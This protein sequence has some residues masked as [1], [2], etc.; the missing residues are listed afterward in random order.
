V[1]DSKESFMSRTFPRKSS[2]GARARRCQVAGLAVL[3]LLVSSLRGDVTGAIL[4]TVSDPTGA[5][6]TRAK[7]S[8]HSESTGLS[9]E[10]VTDGLG[11]YEFLA[12]PVGED[13]ALTVEA[14]GFRGSTR[15]GVTLLVNQR[16]RADFQLQVGEMKETVN[17]QAEAVQVES[18][19]TQ[20]GDV[21]Q[22]RKMTALP[23]N[24]RSYLD[25]LGLQAGVVPYTASI[26]GGQPYIPV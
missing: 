18:S 17:V 22:D 23:L 24:G 10:T 2:D 6:V 20:L 15:I 5:S 1:L 3:L 4:G 21:I 12:V 13:Y 7:V 26:S 9:R 14:A 25:L 8:L 11:N 19:S 16:L